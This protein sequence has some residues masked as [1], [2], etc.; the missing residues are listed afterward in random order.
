MPLTAALLLFA[1]LHAG[2]LTATWDPVLG[3]D[4]RPALVVRV[5]NAPAALAAECEVGGQQLSWQQDELAAGAAWTL[6]LPVVPEVAEARCQVVARFANGLSEGIDVDMRWRSAA[7][8][9][10]GDPRQVSVDLSARRADLHCGLLAVRA[11]VEALDRDGAPLLLEEVALKPR[12][13][14][15]VVRWTKGGAERATRLRFTLLDADGSAQ[16]YDVAV[17]T[18]VKP[19]SRPGS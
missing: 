12:R 2:E 18:H 3:P 14:L 19:G 15:V 16:I 17:V 9:K 11:V 6:E 10:S 4:E 8:A 1:T 5:P 7:T 13:G